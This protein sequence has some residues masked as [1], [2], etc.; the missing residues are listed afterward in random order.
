MKSMLRAAIVLQA[1]LTLPASAQWQ[2][3]VGGSALYWTN[4]EHDNAGQQLVREAGWLPGV[5]L[6]AAYSNNDLSWFAQAE[7]Y[8]GAIAYHGQTQAGRAVDSNTSTGVTL[9]R[10]GGAH[11]LKANY[12]VFAALEWERWTRDIE[13]AQGAAGLQE[14]ADTRRWSA[15][16]E[17][18]WIAPGSDVVSVDG[19]LILAEPERLQ[20]GFSGLLDP[21]SLKTNWSHGWRAGASLRLASKPHLEWRANVESIKVRRSADAALSRNGRFIATLAQ[22]EHDKLSIT[23]TVALV[24]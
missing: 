23:I 21:A 20:V 13:G 7:R 19:A 5:A 17:K 3:S 22:P 6:R 9:L 24:F 2:G 11:A 16:I 1:L 4:T 10:T 18:K 12:R 15:G 8:R 14:K